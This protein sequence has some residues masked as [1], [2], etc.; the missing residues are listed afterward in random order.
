MKN[1]KLLLVNVGTQSVHQTGI[2]IFNFDI[3]L[4]C[5]QFFFIIC[6]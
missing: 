5:L 3:K 6:I 1:E 4:F 2:I